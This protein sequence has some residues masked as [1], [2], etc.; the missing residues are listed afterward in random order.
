MNYR[1]IF[2]VILTFTPLFLLASTPSNGKMIKCV[3]IDAGHGGHDPGAVSPNKTKEKDVTLSIALKL[4]ALIEKN[5]PEV[6]VVYTRK[7]D[8]FVELHRRAGIANDNKAD[9]FISIHCNSSKKSEP[10]GVETWVM[11]LHKSAANL[12]VAKKEN[13]SILMEKNH[14][15]KYDGFKPN[16]AEAYIIF[17]LFQNMYLNNSLVFANAIQLNFKNKLK[18]L[19]RGVKQAGFLVLYKTAMPSV[20]VEVGFLSNSHDEKYINKP[21][22]RE[23]IV[24][25][26]Y[27]SFVNYKNTIEGTSDVAAQTAPL[28]TYDQIKTEIDT[29]KII[30]APTPRIEI[31]SLTIKYIDNKSPKTQKKE[32]KIDSVGI[33][34]PNRPTS[35]ENTPSV[36]FRVQFLASPNVKDF[37]SKELALLDNVF[38]YKHGSAYKYTAGMFTT[39]KEAVV[40][41]TKLQSMG[42][43]DS[44]VVAF[45]NNIRISPSEATRL[46]NEQNK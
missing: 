24:N 45:N 35:E 5:H 18:F 22:G 15:V 27:M 21:E 25:S 3:V 31:D 9:L 38:E 12:E 39:I 14:S 2:F 46:L 29:T 13:A 36:V 44:F 26:L 32:P 43:S 33:Y 16:S 7:T 34:K 37:N 17:S 19:D 11:G 4:G 20:L 40:Y 42:Y 41:Q 8:V 6:K 23:S 30:K 28:Y 10:F 1:Q